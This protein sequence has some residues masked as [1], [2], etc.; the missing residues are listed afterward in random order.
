M[1][2]DNNLVADNDAEFDVLILEAFKIEED[3]EH[4]EGKH[5]DN[6]HSFVS[7]AIRRGI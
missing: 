4:C 3:C 6:N 5:F 1:A 2:E 7:T